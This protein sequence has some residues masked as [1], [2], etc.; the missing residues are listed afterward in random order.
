MCVLM[1]GG[2]NLGKIDKNLEDAGVTQLVH[3]DGRKNTSLRIPQKADLI[4]V[5]TDFINHNTSKLIKK[6]AKDRNIPVVYS[7]RSWACLLCKIQPFLKKNCCAN[8]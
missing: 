6:Q 4:V 8:K 7:K 5:L 2:D 3:I 1:I